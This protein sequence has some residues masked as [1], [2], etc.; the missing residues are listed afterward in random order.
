M[1]TRQLIKCITINTLLGFP[2]GHTVSGDSF[3]NISILSANIFNLYPNLQVVDTYNNNH[4]VTIG[5]FSNLVEIASRS[6]VGS[7][8]EKVFLNIQQDY[9]LI[10]AAFA[11]AQNLRLVDL[12]G[13]LN[14]PNNCFENCSNLKVVWGQKTRTVGDNAFNKCINIK[15]IYLPNVNQISQTAFTNANITYIVV[16]QL[17]IEK[18]KHQNPNAQVLAAENYKADDLLILADI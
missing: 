13:T 4:N 1:K 7:F 6:L 14:I 17:L 15:L 5:I 8:I 12:G 10:P 9:R 11:D 16:P 3:P 2:M 18:V